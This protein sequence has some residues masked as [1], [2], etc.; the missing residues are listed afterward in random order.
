M[1]VKVATK[2]EKCEDQC[3]TL[4]GVGISNHSRILSIA[5]KE[6]LCTR[7]FVYVLKESIDLSLQHLL[8]AIATP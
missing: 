4:R 6:C 7:S 3:T 2:L 8:H 1:G 5:V